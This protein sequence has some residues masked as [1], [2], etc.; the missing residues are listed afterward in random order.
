MMRKLLLLFPCCLLA[1]DSN[2]SGPVAGYVGRV[3]PPKV[4]AITGA[5][6]GYVFSDPLPLPDGA[7]KVYVGRDVAL[8]DRGDA[9]LLM[10]NL[11]DGQASAV[12]GAMPAPDWVV[13]SASGASA[14][15]FSSA[16]LQ[17]LLGTQVVLDVDTTTL[18]EQPLRAA[19]SEDGSLVLI[20]SANALYS[21][22]TAGARLILSA[23]EILS[24]ATLPNGAD[25][26]VANRSTGS[27]Q[28]VRNAS[29]SADVSTLVSGLA[30]ISRIQPSS[31]GATIFV[32]RPG[33]K[34]VSSVD[35]AS[36]EVQTLDA[37]IAG[38][39]LTPLR[40]RDTFVICS[41]RGEPGA[42][43]VRDGADSRVLFIP[44]V[45]AGESAQ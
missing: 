43:F 4:R 26:V 18:P 16:R 2:L 34:A 33:V 9:G 32:A 44:A 37:G 15:L 41:K 7:R 28:I 35:V 19:V 12:D 10:L 27:I 3:S 21:L 17:V 6:G 39:E 13:F 8:V 29:A 40:N 23:G 30:G 25:A 31:D 42:I 20:A 36:G 14:V 22:S 11:R 38:G 1:A 24:I 45:R 5:P